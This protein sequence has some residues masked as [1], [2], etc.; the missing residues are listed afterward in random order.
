MLAPHLSHTGSQ[1]TLVMKQGRRRCKS[2]AHWFHSN[3]DWRNHTIEG[4]EIHVGDP[5][6]VQE[7]QPSGHVQRNLPSHPW[8]ASPASRGAVS[9]V[10]NVLMSNWQAGSSCSSDANVACMPRRQAHFLFHRSDPSLS[11]FSALYRSPAC[12]TD[13]ARAQMPQILSLCRQR[14]L[15]VRELQVVRLFKAASST[16]P[17]GEARLMCAVSRQP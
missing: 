5:V 10:T 17:S 3:S 11:F 6:G 12:E 1:A 16:A 13:A 14:D 9:G 7:G 15:A 4:L 8:A 2:G